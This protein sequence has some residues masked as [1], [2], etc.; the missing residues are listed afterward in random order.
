MI[1]HHF[2][3]CIGLTFFA[4]MGGVFPLSL[5]T[6]GYGGAFPIQETAMF[7][8]IAVPIGFLTALG[9]VKVD[10]KRKVLKFFLGAVFAASLGAVS[11]TALASM[12]YACNG[13]GSACGYEW[14]TR[15]GGQSF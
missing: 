6:G 2:P 3:L 4:S 11:W 10:Q 5:L 12:A 7:W 15:Q 13:V 9:L 1:K 14:E 8:A